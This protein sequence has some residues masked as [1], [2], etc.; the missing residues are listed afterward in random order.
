MVTV[1]ASCTPERLTL[2][3]ENPAD[4]DR[5]RKTGTGLGLANVRAR[6]RAVFGDEASIH[7]TEQHGMWR[8]DVSVPATRRRE[9][10]RR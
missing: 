10:E 3:V 7:W 2:T 5:P 4:P 6:L 1:T 9:D 8:V